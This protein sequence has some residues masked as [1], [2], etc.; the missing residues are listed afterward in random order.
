MFHASAAPVAQ[1][2]KSNAV[3]LQ[4]VLRIARLNPLLMGEGKGEGYEIFSGASSLVCRTSP[5]FP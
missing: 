5:F 2:S 4:I 3:D 1:C